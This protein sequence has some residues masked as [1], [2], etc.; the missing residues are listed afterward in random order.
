MCEIC[1][2]ILNDDFYYAV[3]IVNDKV[4]SIEPLGLYV[5]EWQSRQYKEFSELSKAISDVFIARME[6]LYY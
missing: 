5:P 6:T 3:H 1:I 4:K 2:A